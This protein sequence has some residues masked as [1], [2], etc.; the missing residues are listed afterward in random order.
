MKLSV[1]LLVFTFLLID[2][3]EAWGSRR[4]RWRR[5]IRI[6]CRTACQYKCTKPCLWCAPVCHYACKNLC[7]RKKRQVLGN[8]S[9]PCDFAAWDKNGDGHV[10]KEEFASTAYSVV[11]EGDMALAFQATDTDGMQTKL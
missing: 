2:G 1:L 7:G 6:V 4:S 10:D 11:K 3:S 9:L 8:V 5:V